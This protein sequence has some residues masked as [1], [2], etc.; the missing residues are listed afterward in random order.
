MLHDDWT[1]CAEL[2]KAAGH[3]TRLRILYELS[4]EPRCVGDLEDPLGARQANVSQHL[5]V[6]RHAGLVDYAQDGAMRCYYLPRPKT[7]RTLLS[8]A[9][10]DEPPHQ[11]TPEQLRRL[12]ARTNTTRA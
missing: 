8:L 12:K 6:L 9:R 2:L 7:V 10:Q 4:L 11:R 3:P 1:Q 5:T